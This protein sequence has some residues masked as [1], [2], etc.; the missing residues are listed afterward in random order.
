MS[1]FQYIIRYIFQ[2]FII[3]HSNKI[4]HFLPTQIKRSSKVEFNIYKNFVIFSLNV[5]STKN[6][7][8]LLWNKSLEKSCKD[9]EANDV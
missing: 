9:N 3:L 8:L 1:V 6:I 7:I 5:N 2:I 4:I